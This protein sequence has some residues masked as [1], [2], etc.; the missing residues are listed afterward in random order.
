[1]GGRRRDGQWGKN[2]EEGPPDMH[3]GRGHDTSERNPHAHYISMFLLFLSHSS[4][5]TT[6]RGGSF[7]G[8]SQACSIFAC[9]KKSF[10]A[11]FPLSLSTSPLPPSLLPPPRSSV[12]N[13]RRLKTVPSFDFSVFRSVSV[14]S[15]LRHCSVQCPSSA[16]V[17]VVA[18]ASH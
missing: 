10:A 8:P 15:R 11:F 12:I 5:G 1:M 9:R 7:Q 6:S 13:Q 16:A 14:F 17:V 2:E 4:C 3:V 18:G